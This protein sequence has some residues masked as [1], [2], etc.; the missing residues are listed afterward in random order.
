MEAET[1]ELRAQLFKKILRGAQT[2]IFVIV[3][4]QEREHVVHCY[5]ISEGGKRPQMQTSADGVHD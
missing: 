2:S 4:K 5:L 1:H 3:Q